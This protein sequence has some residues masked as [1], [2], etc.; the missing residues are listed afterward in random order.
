[1]NSGPFCWLRQPNAPGMESPSGGCRSRRGP[2]SAGPSGSRACLGGFRYAP[3][4]AGPP[5]QEAL[6]EIGHP[7]M[8]TGC[9]EAPASGGTWLSTRGFCSLGR[10]ASRT[11]YC[12][13]VRSYREGRAAPRFRGCALADRCLPRTSPGR[14]RCSPGSLRFAPL[15]ASAPPSA[16]LRSGADR[17][18][19]PP[20]TAPLS[21]PGRH[22][23][24][25]SRPGLPFRPASFALPLSRAANAHGGLTQKAFSSGRLGDS[26]APVHPVRFGTRSAFPGLPSCS[27]VVWQLRRRGCSLSRLSTHAAAP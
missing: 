6:L 21:A 15:F 16:S 1:M 8:Q 11:R 7:L 9:R 18:A 26:L 24:S 10:R 3:P 17:P 22:G 19:A 2:A 25:G 20:R 23:L 27:G 14:F 4:G 13:E 5:Q 12:G